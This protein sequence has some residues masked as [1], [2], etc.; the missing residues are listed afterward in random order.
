MEQ[1]HDDATGGVGKHAFDEVLHAFPALN[2]CE[3]DLR[4]DSMKGHSGHEHYMYHVTWAL[5]SLG[6]P[7][8]SPKLREQ[9]VQRDLVVHEGRGPR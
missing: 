4:V 1:A 7:S 3:N 8:R 5:R 6:I 2:H 9:G